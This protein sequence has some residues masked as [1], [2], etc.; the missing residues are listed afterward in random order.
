MTFW[1]RYQEVCQRERDLYWQ[2]SFNDYLEMVRADPRI[3]RRA[4]ARLYDMICAA[5]IEE[6]PKGK[7]YKLF[8]D[9]LF[10]MNQVLERIVEDY[11]HPAALGLEVRKRILLLMGPVSGGKSTLVT[12]LK[13]GLEA[14]SRTPEGALYGIKGCPM[15]EEPLHLVPAEL[16]RDLARELGVVIE[17]EL[18][19]L[20]RHRLIHEYE[21]R[22]ERV[23]VERILISETERVGIGTFSP[24][25]PK[26]QDIAELV[27][28]LDF[29]K[30][31][32]YGSESDPR[33][34]RFDG[35]INRAN[36]G[37]LEFQELLKCDQKFLYHLLS[38]TQE[39][40]FKTGRYALI[41]AD[42][43]LIAHTNAQEYR[44]FIA[45][46][47][48]EGLKSRLLVVKVPYTLEVSEEEKIYRKSLRGINFQVH[49]APFALQAAALFAVLTRVKAG[50][51][52][53][54]ELLAEVK[55]QE[56]PEPAGEDPDRGMTGV[57]PRFIQE[58]LS[59]VI[60]RS[61]GGCVTAVRVI[62]SLRT[63][64]MDDPGF[65]PET[66][67]RYL[68]LLSLV[69]KEYA[70]F[71]RRQLREASLTAF[72]PEARGLF[73]RYIQALENQESGQNC[74]KE[75][76]LMEGVE[77]HLGI[78]ANA[79]FL[80][81]KEILRHLQKWRQEGKEFRYESHPELKEGIQEKL[82]QDLQGLLRL[83]L[84]QPA[85]DRGDYRERL[86]NS[87]GKQ[88]Y[89]PRCGE[90]LLEYWSSSLC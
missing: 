17:G 52:N 65:T 59:S 46:G 8:Q 10:G 63:G 89:C 18:C 75:E 60:A 81:R 55:A 78:S 7:V 71:V 21:G 48:N 61:K 20:C 79:R 6:T 49:L 50:E 16:R 41:S 77:R 26:S 57:D 32:Q 34:Y 54:Q 70:S 69:E 31:E 39:G 3:A 53:T 24:S 29:A 80:W 15:Q 2:G 25:D 35:E 58:R 13:R 38:L 83:Y 47:A 27:G 72:A 9:H 40:N 12:L 43:V 30:L 14:Y 82:W 86:L 66:K 67:K 85:K 19:P 68:L 62:D 33:A 1:E 4:H 22:I 42:E 88:G 64:I 5:G 23:P 51:R 45:A 37:L 84:F 56:Q 87:L 11:F 76:E 28:S 36:R 74:R 90:A 73:Q 44:S